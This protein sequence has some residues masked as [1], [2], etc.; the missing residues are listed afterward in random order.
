MVRASALVSTQASPD[1][2]LFRLGST[3][4][5]RRSVLAAQSNRSHQRLWWAT[6][7]SIYQHMPATASALVNA[8]K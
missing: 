8:Q 1:N 4:S 5:R 2:S 7:T 3:L 6:Q